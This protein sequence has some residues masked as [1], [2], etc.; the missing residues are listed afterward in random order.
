MS[1]EAGLTHFVPVNTL[2]PR[3]FHFVRILFLKVVPVS[4]KVTLLHL[5]L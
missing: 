1:C 4:I 5:A 2:Q 3:V